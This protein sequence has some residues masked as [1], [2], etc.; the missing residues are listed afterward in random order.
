[1]ILSIAK[2]LFLAFFDICRLV[3][4]PQDIPESR[5]LLTLCAIVYGLLSIW[6]ASL[7]QPI[8]SAIVV[9]TVELVL[10]MVFTLAVL[11][12]SG[13][14]S[15]WTQTVTALVGTGIIISIL[16]FPIYILLGVG[17][18]N[19]VELSTFQN[20]GLLLLAALSCWNIAIMAHILRHALEINF[21]IALFLAI[22]YIW[23][24]F[25]F[26]SA[27]VPMETN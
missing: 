26:T 27:I 14:S 8:E 9:G 13:K 1:M 10:I 11:Q 15:R 6:L 25:S 20:I 3:K 23:I 21:A 7:S 16:A 22:T 5:N 24:I 17:E 19:E 2:V 12:A 4:R 18:L